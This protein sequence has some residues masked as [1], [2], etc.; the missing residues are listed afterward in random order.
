MVAF[1]QDSNYSAVNLKAEANTFEGKE[2]TGKKSTVG[3][4]MR[5]KPALL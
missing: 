1:L 4:W 2:K 5:L 3:C